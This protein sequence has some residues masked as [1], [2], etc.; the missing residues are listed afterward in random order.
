MP[1][2]F[3]DFR[4]KAGALPKELVGV[5]EK[6]AKVLKKYDEAWEKCKDFIIDL[7][8]KEC[9]CK[10]WNGKRIIFDE[11]KKEEK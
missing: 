10:E 2:E 9:G 6:Y 11:K 4:E 3:D 1:D 5:G 7:H 8:T